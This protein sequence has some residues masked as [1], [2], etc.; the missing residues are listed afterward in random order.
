MASVPST[1]FKTHFGKYM[2]RSMME[3]VF[4][5]RRHEE[6]VLI[7]KDEYDRLQALDDAYWTLK[8]EQ[9]EKKGY[10]NTQDSMEKLKNAL[11][12]SE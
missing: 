8:A 7:N 6:S 2:T 5:K 12:Q 11:D 1:Q 4:I 9:A 10:L 3:P